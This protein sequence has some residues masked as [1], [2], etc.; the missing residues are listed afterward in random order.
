MPLQKKLAKERMA[1]GGGDTKSSDV[2]SLGSQL[3]DM[4]I[5]KMQSSRWQA[6]AKVPKR[7]YHAVAVNLP[8]FASRRRFL[9]I[10]T[11]SFAFFNCSPASLSILD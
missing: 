3:A 6:E 7:V 1:A 9:S 10:S 5:K 11:S 2:V 4:G 8:L